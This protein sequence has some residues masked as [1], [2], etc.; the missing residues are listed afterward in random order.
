VTK[1]R[2]GDRI[3]VLCVFDGEWRKAR[4]TLPLRTRFYADLVGR[5]HPA[6]TRS[7]C[8]LRNSE[9]KTWRRSAPKTNQELTEELSASTPKFGASAFG[10][11]ESGARGRPRA[12]SSR[13][14]P[15][16]TRG[17]SIGPWARS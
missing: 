1:I 17:P 11:G 5:C 10:H 16:P 8:Y 2:E 14:L 13:I 15:I 6:I 4:I 12:L 3:E 7:C 9:G